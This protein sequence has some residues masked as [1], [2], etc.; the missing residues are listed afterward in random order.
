MDIKPIV[1]YNQEVYVYV[2]FLIIT[3][4]SLLQR[5]ISKLGMLVL[6]V[7]TRCRK[8]GK[9]KNDNYMKIMRIHLFK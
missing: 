3:L 6:F 1:Y 5:Y 9:A 2:D 4:V 8:I 7:A